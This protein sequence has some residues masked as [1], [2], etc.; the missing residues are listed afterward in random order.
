MK[1]QTKI[2]KRRRREGKTNYTRRLKLLVGK[3]P[4]FVFRKTNRY[5]IL[6]I[7]QSSHAQDKVVHVT[8]SKELLKQGWPKEKTGSLKSLPAAYLSGYL[9]GKKVKDIKGKII[10]DVGL[11]PST[12]GSKIYAALKGFSDAGVNIAHDKKILPTQERI[13]GEN[14]KIDKETFN[15]IKEAIK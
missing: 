3:H 9:L 15:K 4:R 13:E 11:I 5:L 8:N 14:S 6:Q 7:V 2:V 1:R 10:L 12:K